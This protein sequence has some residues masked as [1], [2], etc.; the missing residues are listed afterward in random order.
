MLAVASCLFTAFLEAGF[1]WGRRG[2]ELSW[3]LGNNF[4]PAMLEVG[5]PAAW[6][7]LAFGLLFALGAAG[8]EAL[9]VKAANLAARQT[10]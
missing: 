6:Q 4:N 1:L 5:I 8:S 9:R 10:G 7:V 3:T 2:Y